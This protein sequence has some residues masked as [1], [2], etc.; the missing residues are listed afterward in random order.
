MVLGE[1]KERMIVRREAREKKA[2]DTVDT[3][4]IRQSIHDGETCEATCLKSCLVF[5]S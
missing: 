1:K 5:L 2:D 3:D 4:A